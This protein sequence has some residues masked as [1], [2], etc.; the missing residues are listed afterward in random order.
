MTDKKP[1]WEEEFEGEQFTA[2]N[3]QAGSRFIDEIKLKTFIRNLL[4]QKE[5]EVKAEMRK[6]IELLSKKGQHYNDEWRGGF[7]WAF[8][9]M[10][11]FLDK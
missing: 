3:S 1:D 6:E 8:K 11:K 5:Q 4:A 9:L 2:W 7:A 10:Q